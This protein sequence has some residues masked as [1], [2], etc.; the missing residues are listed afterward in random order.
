MA[1]DSGWLAILEVK[2]L[3]TRFW[4]GESAILS[5]RERVLNRVALVLDGRI[6]YMC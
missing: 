6:N 5:D 2:L 4:A 1:L 3:T